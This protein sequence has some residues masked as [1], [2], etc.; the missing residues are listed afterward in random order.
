MA[1]QCSWCKRIKNK[2][3]GEWEIGPAF[4]EIKHGICSDCIKKLKEEY[5]RE[6]N[7]RD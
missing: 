6:K 7:E 5:E 1:V 3:T 2:I 4:L